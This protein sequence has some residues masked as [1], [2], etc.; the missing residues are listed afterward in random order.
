MAALDAPGFHRL[1]HSKSG[2]HQ[3]V[4]LNRMQANRLEAAALE[5]RLCGDAR[6]DEN[7]FQVQQL[8][9][10]FDTLEQSG[11][12]ANA[13]EARMNEHHVEMP[14]CLE[15]GK[16]HRPAVD[17][18]NPSRARQSPPGPFATIYARP[19]LDVSRSVVTARYLPDGTLKY[20]DNRIEIVVPI[21]P[22]RYHDVQDAD[23][24]GGASTLIG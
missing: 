22:Y 4:L 17:F 20:F 9:L 21:V 18:G 13:L 2:E 3:P 12:N 19:G 8:R 23:A 14:I 7:L 5:E 15:V 24:G 6:F 11:S 1:D 10:P 16:A